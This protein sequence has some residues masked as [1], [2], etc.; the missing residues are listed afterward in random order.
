[1]FSK[2]TSDKPQRMR[3]MISAG[4]LLAASGFVLATLLNPAT[5]S[6]AEQ[7]T[8]P[9]MALPAQAMT[10]VSGESVVFEADEVGVES[11]TPTP[12]PTPVQTSNG[13][14]SGSGSGVSV[15]RA[16][17]PDPGSAQA[18]ARDMLAA[19]GMGDDQYACL[20]NLWMRES[21][22]NMYAQNPSS[23]AYGIPQALPG[24]KMA[25]AGADWQTNAVT[26]ITWGIGYIEGRYGTPCG[27]WGHSQ[28]VGWY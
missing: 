8:L 20:Y 18:I 22:W 26:Q 9:A 23:G 12:S 21:N 13:S 16:A 17:A 14:N 19:R 27:A 24:S 25:S 1:M 11:P 2:H 4:A 7:E 10:E 3:G 6:Y 5:T 15:P 28:A